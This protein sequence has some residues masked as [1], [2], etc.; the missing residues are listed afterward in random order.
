M[1]IFFTTVVLSTEL[2]EEKIVP[3][4]RCENGG[5]PDNAPVVVGFRDDEEDEDADEEEDEDDFD[6]D[7]DDE[8]LDD[9]WKE[10]DDENEDDEDDEEDDE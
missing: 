7:Q 6:E 2:L 3:M 5:K 10:V 8:E 1:N 9:D 4:S